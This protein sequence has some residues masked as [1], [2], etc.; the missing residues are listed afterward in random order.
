MTVKLHT[1]H[2]CKNSK[3][4]FWFLRSTRCAEHVEIS[5]KIQGK[6]L[7]SFFFSSEISKPQAEN[8]LVFYVRSLIELENQRK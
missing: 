2:I 6:Y 5:G 7:F 1:D 4:V 8:H 3:L